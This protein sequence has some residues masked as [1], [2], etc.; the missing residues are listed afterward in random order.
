[1]LN[2]LMDYIGFL[3]LL[4]LDIITTLSGMNFFYLKTGSQRSRS[5]QGQMSLESP[6]ETLIPA[7]FLISTIGTD[8]GLPLVMDT[9]TFTCVIM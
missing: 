4:R 2:A 5:Q 9:S 6:R 7:S 8:L 1:M 3:E